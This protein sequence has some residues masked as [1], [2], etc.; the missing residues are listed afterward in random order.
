MGNSDILD[1][2]T[3]LALQMQLCRPRRKL[4]R[5]DDDTGKSDQGG[6]CVCLLYRLA[7]M[8]PHPGIGKTRTYGQF[9][10]WNQVGTRLDEGL[11]ILD[12]TFA[13]LA[14]AGIVGGGSIWVT[15]VL[16]LSSET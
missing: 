7:S 3:T 10:E 15:R 1:R 4:T 6:K 8:P 14:A 9:T 2:S 11:H 5:I 12:R 13:W 16:H